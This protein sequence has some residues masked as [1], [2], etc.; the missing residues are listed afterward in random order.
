LPVD[1]V[2]R[3]GPDRL[4]AAMAPAFARKRSP[5]AEPAPR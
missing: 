4:Y 3:F 2:V 5:L 1:D